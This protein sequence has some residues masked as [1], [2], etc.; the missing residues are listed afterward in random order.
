[1]VHSVSAAPHVTAVFET[2][3]TPIMAHHAA[4][5]AEFAAQGVNLNCTARCISASVAA[6]QRAPTVNSRW[7]AD[8]PEVFASANIGIGTALGDQGLVVPVIHKAQSLLGIA[9]QLQ[10]V[11]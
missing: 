3:F 9:Q 5:K 7:H 2:D 8:R 1:M 6:M 10:A 4:K 11:T